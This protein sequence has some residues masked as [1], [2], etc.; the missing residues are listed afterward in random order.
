MLHDH[1]SRENR[2]TQA[3]FECVQCGFKENADVVGALNVLRAGHARIACEVN[4]IAGQQQEPS[5]AT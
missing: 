3:V 4:L 5:E 2:Q 1:V